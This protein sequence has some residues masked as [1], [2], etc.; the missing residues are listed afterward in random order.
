MRQV[1]KIK[2][3]FLIF[4]F[5]IPNGLLFSQV[6]PKIPLKKLPKVP[7]PFE[8]L[9]SKV[10]P[11]EAERGSK[12]T[13]YGNGFLKRPFIRVEFSSTG[14]DLNQD[15]KITNK[16][17][18]SLEVIVPPHALTG[19]IQVTSGA[20]DFEKIVTPFIFTVLRPPVIIVFFP[21]TGQ[22]GTEVFI[23]GY[24]IGDD[25]EVKFYNEKRAKSRIARE[26]KVTE[27]GV[28]VTL[29][30]EVPEGASTGPITVL[31]PEGSF[32]TSTHFGVR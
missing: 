2:L 24:N 19:K 21:N 16:T 11:E 9:V 1:L 12:I 29:I 13:I 8:F 15:A 22:I 6:P 27:K 10:V 3:I 14:G 18:M 7:T 26:Y 31:T 20:T 30:A 17:N 5:F 28:E 23:K 32:T 25:T 4:L